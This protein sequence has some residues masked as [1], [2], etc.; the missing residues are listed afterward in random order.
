ME[1]AK[2]QIYPLLWQS[3]ENNIL[4]TLKNIQ[5]MKK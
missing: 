3:M 1:E 4:G 2:L 5:N